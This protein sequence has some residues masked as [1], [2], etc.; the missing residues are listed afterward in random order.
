MTE[1]TTHSQP[2]AQNR[3]QTV[4]I[5]MQDQGLSSS[6]EINLEATLY[7]PQGNGPFPVVIFN[8]G[9]TGPGMIP[10]DLTENPWGFGAYLLK[11][12][13]AL[14]IPMRRGRGKSEGAYREP[15]Q[16]SLD[17]SRLGIR[18]AMESLDAVYNFLRKQPWTD[19]NKIVLSGVSRGGILSTIYAAERPGSAIGVLNFS[20]GWMSERCNF[21]AGMDINTELFK[22]AGSKS[23]VPNLFLYAANDSFYSVPVIKR[24]PDTVRAG[25][26]EVEF[27][28][29]NLGD[30]VDG[31]RLFSMHG[32]EWIPE[33]DTFLTK[34]GVWKS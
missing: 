21:F 34:L 30:G 14:L 15:Y 26:G 5:A 19:L 22:E 25:G 27:K 32:T 13:I 3:G 28:L 17:Q 31:H 10:L 8:H 9:S 29:Y 1:L 20:G 12:D 2:A 18:Y 4:W 11:K 23:K 33:V 24:Y 16:C 6:R 7:R